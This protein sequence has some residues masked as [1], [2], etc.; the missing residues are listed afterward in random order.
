MYRLFQC[1]HVAPSAE[2]ERKRPLH[3]RQFTLPELLVA[4][5]NLCTRT[6]SELLACAFEIEASPE[7]LLY[8]AAGR[9]ARGVGSLDVR[10]LWAFT[11]TRPRVQRP[12]CA[13]TQ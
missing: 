4:L 3:L 6:Q 13:H 2:R 12:C 11:L 1:C 5:V 7:E 10:A 9:A 8:V